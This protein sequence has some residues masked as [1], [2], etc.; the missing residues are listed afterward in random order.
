MVVNTSKTR[1]EAVRTLGYANPSVVYYHLK[2]FG[3]PHPPQWKLKPGVSKQRRGRV[4]DVILKTEGDRGWVGG[5]TQGEGCIRVHYSRK[6]DDTVLELSVGMTDPA[7]VFSFCDLCGR[8]R[9]AKPSP[10]LNP[11]KPMWIGV[12]GGL[13]AYRVLQ[14]ILPFLE[15]QKLE[16]AKRALEFFAP[17]GYRKGQ[18]TAYDVWPEGEFPLRKRSYKRFAQSLKAKSLEASERFSPLRGKNRINKPMDRT[19]L[20]IADVLLEARPDGRTIVEIMDDSGASWTAVIHHLKHLEENLLV[21]KEKIYQ[22]LGAPRLL[23]KS[24]PKMAEWRNRGWIPDDP[25]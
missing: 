11:R 3:I 23:Y 15:G 12:I 24:T 2:K 21:T 4:S 16:E 7:P 14:E 25:S 18:W 22:R 13:R 5:L 20:R 10:R 19:C 1:T 9:P 8:K 17:D 6:S